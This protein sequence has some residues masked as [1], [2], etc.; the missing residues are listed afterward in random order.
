ALNG[1]PEVGADTRKRV[2]EAARLLGYQPN[3]HARRLAT[4]R[5]HAIGHVFPLDR[6]LMIDPLFSDFVAGAADV[7]SAH[8]FEVMLH[9][10]GSE[11]ELSVYRRYAQTS[12]VDGVVVLGPRVNDPRIALLTSLNLP[13]IVHGRLDEYE[14][15]YGWLDIDNRGAFHRAT[16]LL[17]DLGHRRIGLINGAVDMT[18]A[19]HRQQGYEQALAAK[20]IPPDPLIMSSV[21]MTEENGYRQSKRILQLAN[22][23]T[24]LLLSSMLLV[25]GAM[26]ALNEMNLQI[27]RDIS[28]IAHDDGLPFLNADGLVPS[29]TTT[30]SPI[31]AAG[32]RVAELL[33]SLITDPE[34]EKPQ[35]LWSVDLIVRG[36][37]GPASN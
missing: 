8:G 37:T 18:F 14:T 11:D 13:F 4:G 1:Y 9:A 36:S 6:S 35:E 26:R 22:R 24:A 31:R 16:K 7:Y 3:P 20:G 2:D 32:T 34:T 33:L 29:L 19:L 17:T 21:L 15:G 28:L 12:A 30:R 5:S 10:G 27:G 25:S 23:P